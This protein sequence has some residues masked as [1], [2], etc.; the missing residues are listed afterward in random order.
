VCDSHPDVVYRHEPEA[1]RPPGDVPLIVDESDYDQYAAGLRT[2]SAQLLGMSHHRVSGKLP[3]LP[4]HYASWIQQKLQLFSIVCARTADRFSVSVPV[5]DPAS[6]LGA[7]NP[8]V[9]WKSVAGTSRLGVLMHAHPEAI[10]VLIMRHP[11]GYVS[12]QL[13]GRSGNH[14]GNV[15]KGQSP[16]GL[17]QPLALVAERGF[18]LSNE[19]FLS[20]SLAEQLAWRWLIMFEQTKKSVTYLISPPFGTTICVRI[21]LTASRV[22]SRS[23]V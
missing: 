4:K 11:C 10:G 1:V 14:F 15:G 21:P 22:F 17:P 6:R 2:Y 8:P 3:L 16:R 13:R 18:G 7:A 9:V 20:L 5:Y 19:Q 23:P 12:S